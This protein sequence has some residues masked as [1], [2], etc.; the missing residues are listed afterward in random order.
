M[1]ELQGLI[2]E[3]P[4]QCTVLLSARTKNIRKMDNTEYE[5]DRDEPY[6]HRIEKALDLLY[7]EL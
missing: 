4:T 5:F 7:R 1:A 3:F 6:E 2:T